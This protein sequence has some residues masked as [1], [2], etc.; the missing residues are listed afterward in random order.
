MAKLGDVLGSILAEVSRA[1]AVADSL[2]RDLAADYSNDP[3]LASL[4]VPRVAL[5]EMTVTLR[6]VVDEVQEAP[7]VAVD[8]ARFAQSFDASLSTSVIPRLI[9]EVPGLQ[10][11][12]RQRLIAAMIAQDADDAPDL[13]RR[14]IGREP[15]RPIDREPLGPLRPNRPAPPVRPD[16]PPAR[17]PIDGELIQKAIGGDPAPVAEATAKQL[18]GRLEGVPAE[19]RDKLG[20]QDQFLDAVRRAAAAQAAALADQAKA[21]AEI[22]TA[23][24]SKI[25]IGVTKADLPASGTAGVQE[26]SLRLSGPD[27]DIVIA[28]GP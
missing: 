25:Q 4:G 6:F 22:E 17:L 11:D 16:L 9:A 3:V 26:L 14:P 28:P 10:P 21:G 19:L 5:N 23:L 8:G 13:G 7:P 1:R 27:L 24:R 20:P 18:V 2:T 12:E 15:L